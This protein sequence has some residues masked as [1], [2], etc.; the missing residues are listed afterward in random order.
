[1]ELGTQKEGPESFVRR[2]KDLA[3]HQLNGAPK[4]FTRH[5]EC[6]STGSSHRLEIAS[7]S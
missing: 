7:M 4:T 2:N 6:L 5:M 3:A 1:M